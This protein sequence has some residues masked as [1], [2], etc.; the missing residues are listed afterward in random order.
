MIAQCDI[1][2]SISQSTDDMDSHTFKGPDGVCILLIREEGYRVIGR[3]P[4]QLE[5]GI[6]YDGF[7]LQDAMNRVGEL[8]GMEMVQFVQ[9][10]VPTN[11]KDFTKLMTR[12]N[13]V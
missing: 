9:P 10:S 5:G 6:M 12:D 3:Q 4:G 7:S 8:I 1:E 2:P 13:L 11:L